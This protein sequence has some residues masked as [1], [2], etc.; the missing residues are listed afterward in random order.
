ML[1]LEPAYVQEHA[2]NPP[3]LG[4]RHAKTLIRC[5][6]ILEL[7][8][9]SVFHPAAVNGNKGK[10]VSSSWRQIYCADFRNS[11][12]RNWGV[13]SEGW[14][15]VVSEISKCHF[16]NVRFSSLC[17]SCWSCWRL[18]C[19][20]QPRGGCREDGTKLFSEAHGERRSSS[21]QK[22]IQGRFRLGITRH[23]FTVSIAKQYSN[24]ASHPPLFW[25]SLLLPWHIKYWSTSCYSA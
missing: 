8:I 3:A 16:L 12:G 5:P 11:I 20:Q 13:A 23:F 1:V 15:W 2:G 10:W 14:K 25:T 7:S 18:K 22:F 9:T 6:E 17:L 21:R 24:K 4:D 19:A